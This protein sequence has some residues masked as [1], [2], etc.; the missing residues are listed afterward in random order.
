LDSP[1]YRWAELR[2]DYCSRVVEYLK[3]DQFGDK[4]FN[5]NPIGIT[6]TPPVYWVYD[7]DHKQIDIEHNV[8]ME[9]LG[10]Q[11]PI[12]P[13]SDYSCSCITVRVWLKVYATPTELALNGGAI[14][15]NNK[16]WTEQ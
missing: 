4:D 3:Y 16:E 5:G 7:V 8:Q 9:Y 14:P 15:I 10:K 13:E 6:R 1:S 2:E 11:I 12:T